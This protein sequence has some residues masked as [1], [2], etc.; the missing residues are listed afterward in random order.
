MKHLG[1]RARAGFYLVVAVLMVSVSPAVLAVEWVDKYVANLEPY[2]VEPGQDCIYFTL[3][4]V[5]RADASLPG[6]ASGTA[7]FAIPRT[8]P[9]A[10]DVYAMLLAAKLAAR[11]VIV[12]TTG[13]VACRTYVGVKSVWMR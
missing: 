12:A 7:W 9:G 13:E 6:G 3:E 5:S 11:P 2:F 1:R 8:N 10:R 4:G